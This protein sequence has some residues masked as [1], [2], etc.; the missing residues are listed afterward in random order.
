MNGPSPCRFLPVAGEYLC[1]TLPTESCLGVPRSIVPV[2]KSTNVPLDSVRHASEMHHSLGIRPRTN[3]P[4]VSPGAALA[5][6]VK[7]AVPPEDA[8]AYL[9]RW[10]GRLRRP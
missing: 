1:S 5:A 7:A 9:C 3:T 10:T 8:S 4:P 6:V 2:G